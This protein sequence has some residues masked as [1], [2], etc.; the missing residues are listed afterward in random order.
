[1]ELLNMMTEQN[2]NCEMKDWKI[3]GYNKAASKLAR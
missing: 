2:K 3:R 1:M